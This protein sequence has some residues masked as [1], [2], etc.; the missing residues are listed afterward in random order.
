MLSSPDFVVWFDP[1]DRTVGSSVSSV[2]ERRVGCDEMVEL[3]RGWY[4]ILEG[5]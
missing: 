3:G 4:E 5:A 2:G 1:E